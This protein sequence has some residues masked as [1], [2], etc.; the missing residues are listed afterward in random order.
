MTFTRLEAQRAGFITHYT[1]P[2]LIQVSHRAMRDIF[3]DTHLW[4]MGD[5]FSKLAYIYYGSPT[6]WWVIAWF[7]ERPTEHH[8]R[9]GDVLKIPLPLET[10]LENYGG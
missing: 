3:V 9:P 7:N 2:R 1:T 8:M 10:V 6:Y 4:Q 5:R